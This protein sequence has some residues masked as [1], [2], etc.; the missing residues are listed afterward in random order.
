MSDLIQA[1]IM[2]AKFGRLGDD[3]PFHGLSLTLQYGYGQQAFIEAVK[4]EATSTPTLDALLAH[5]QTHQIADLV[6]KHVI[7]HVEH[8][9]IRAIGVHTQPF[10]PFEL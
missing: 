6:G 5:Y 10:D 3:V 9:L 2:A 7:A 4:P 8:G 1:T